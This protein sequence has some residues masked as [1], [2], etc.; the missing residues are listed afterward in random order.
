MSTLS[1]LFSIDYWSTQ[2]RDVKNALEILREN[3]I[4][5]QIFLY[6]ISFLSKK[7]SVY[8]FLE[9]FRRNDYTQKNVTKEQLSSFFVRPMR[10]IFNILEE[11]KISV[12]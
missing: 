9:N 4:L 6:E 12:S 5:F 10:C 3:K 11:V 7:I 8:K 1:V 2:R